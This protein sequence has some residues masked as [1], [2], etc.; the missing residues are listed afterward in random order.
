MGAKKALLY[1]HFQTLN[2]TFG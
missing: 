2:N 1:M